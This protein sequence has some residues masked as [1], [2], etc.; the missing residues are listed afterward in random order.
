VQAVLAG[1]VQ[2]A[3]AHDYQPRLAV[4]PALELRE[5]QVVEVFELDVFRGR[6]QAAG[7]HGADASGRITD[8][9]LVREE[10]CDRA[11]LDHCAQSSVA[12]DR[13]KGV[14]ADRGVGGQ[15]RQPWRERDAE[16]IALQLLGKSLGHLEPQRV[17]QEQGD[18]VPIL[19]HGLNHVFV[20][21]ALSQ[22]AIGQR[23]VCHA[24]VEE[25]PVDGI[26]PPPPCATNGLAHLEQCVVVLQVRRD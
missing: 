17:H 6:L 22:P 26:G 10:A 13:R 7:G 8:L 5:A 20:D 3:A 11:V 18:A 9:E 2:L 19:D 12:L 16:T 21:R 23:T 1:R 4:E 14:H 24:Q 15:L 25:G